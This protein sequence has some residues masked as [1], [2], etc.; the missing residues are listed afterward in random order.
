MVRSLDMSDDAIDR[1][2]ASFAT[3]LKPGH[4]L[5]APRRTPDADTLLR[6]LNRDGVVIARSEEARWALLP[7]ER[8][9]GPLLFVGGESLAVPGP[10]APLA[11]ALCA[12]RRF[13]GRALHALATS[14]GARTLLQR[15][16]AMGA[17]TLLRSS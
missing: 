15:L 8:G 10:A 16:F 5:E 14:R 9:A 2:Y 3:R 7:Q 4:S 12:S 13:D 1:W 11:R 17:L 6:K